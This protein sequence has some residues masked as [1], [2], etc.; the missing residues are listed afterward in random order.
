MKPAT[1]NSSISSMV[2]LE[3]E[4]DKKKVG[5]EKMLF[6]LQELVHTEKEYVDKMKDVIKVG[7]AAHVMQINYASV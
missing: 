7:V 5:T 2:S 3:D 1:S 4:D 6:V